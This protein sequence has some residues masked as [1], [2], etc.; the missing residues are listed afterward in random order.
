V[1]K[2]ILV[3]PGAFNPVH[4]Y[5]IEIAKQSLKQFEIITKV[6]F[7]P[8]G[9]KYEKAELIS[10]EHRYNMLKMVCKNESNLEVSDI[11]ITRQNQLYTIQ[12]LE[13]I[14]NENK[15]YDIWLM[16]GADNLKE[17][18]TWMKYSEILQK[19]KVLIVSREQKN[20][21]EIILQ[22]KNLCE[23]KDSFI[24]LDNEI[25]NI[26]YNQIRKLIKEDKLINKFV[27]KI[28][29][30]YIKEHNLYSKTM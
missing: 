1:K 24:F 25:N 3:F 11:E 14:E 23:Y 19:Y 17:F 2:V 20:S 13:L 9:N 16:I 26:N 6:I 28:V 22:N 27:S 12:T 29:K 15:E 4:N 10:G 18:D 8:V 30:D 21:L 5:H 7:V